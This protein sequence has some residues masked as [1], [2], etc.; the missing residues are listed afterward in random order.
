MFTSVRTS[1]AENVRVENW[2]TDGISRAL[3]F[4][5]SDDITM[6]GA[7]Y[8]VLQSPEDCDEVI[9]AAAETKRQMLAAQAGGGAS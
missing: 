3:V 7:V 6:A 2:G 5:A 8:V 1:L 4:G 9:K